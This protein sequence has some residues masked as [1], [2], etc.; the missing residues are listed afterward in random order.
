MV[1]HRK[2]LTLKQMAALLGISWRSYA[3]LEG[4]RYRP[5]AATLLLF[6]S[7][8]LDREI[9]ETVQGFQALVAQAEEKGAA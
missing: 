6:L 8:C 7:L 5:S 3:S 1:R 2:G 4:G 9:V